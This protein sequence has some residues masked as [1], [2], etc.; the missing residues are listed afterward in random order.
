MQ[1]VQPRTWSNS[2][3]VIRAKNRLAN[4][5]SSREIVVKKA[6]H[7][8]RL[9]DVLKTYKIPLGP[10]VS[11][12]GWAKKIRCPFPDH[13]DK[14]PS[15][16]YNYKTDVFNCFVC[17]GG[18]AVEFISK[19]ENKGLKEVAAFLLDNLNIDP[20]DVSL[21][22]TDDSLEIE[23]KLIEFSLFIANIIQ[24]Y[25]DDG[26]KIKL[27]DNYLYGYDSFIETIV[28]KELSLDD[29]SARLEADKKR[30]LAIGDMV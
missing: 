24:R 27:I 30:I 15:F 2:E 13:K 20:Y 10:V 4:K 1:K 19:K 21:D 5:N 12:D 16:A 18:K 17:G 23:K 9:I 29:I 25:K 3:S 11:Q 8:C 26:Y 14:T 6:N 22:F 7:Y 28:T